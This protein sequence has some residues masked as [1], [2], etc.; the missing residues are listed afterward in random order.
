MRPAPPSTAFRGRARSST[1][2]TSGCD[3]MRPAPPST[4]FRGPWGAPAKAP[5]AVTTCGAS[6]LHREPH[7]MPTR[8]ASPSAA[9]RGPIGS[10][11]EGT[12]GCDHMRPAPPS[13]AAP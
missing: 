12:S 7:R 5:V 10:S 1:E 11:T 4:A 8:P 13:T 3:H 6:W 9:F 2:G